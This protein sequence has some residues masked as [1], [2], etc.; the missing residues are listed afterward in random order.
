MTLKTITHPVTGA[1]YK[2]GRKT[3]RARGP[4]LSLH[5]YLRPGLPTPPVSGHYSYTAEHG[6]SQSYLNTEL[7]DCVIAGPLHCIDVFQGVSGQTPTIFDEAQIISLYSAIGGFDPTKTDAQGNNPT[8]DGC[9]EQTMLNYW[10]TNGLC[11]HKISGWMAVKPEDAKLAVWLFGNLVF[12]VN[13]PDAWVNPMPSHNNFVWDAAGAAVP[14]NGHCF[15]GVGWNAN[16]IM[17]DTWGM[18]GVLMDAAVAKYTAPGTGGELYTVI[19][20]EIIAK[21]TQKAPSGF[22]FAELQADFK[23]ISAA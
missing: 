21:A 19:T 8:D 13:L 23:A 2:L 5:R 3:P 15:V 6:L 20:D 18:I 11:G 12:G 4:R 14:D 16:G 1:T 10:A 7:G 9:D 22:A 17:I